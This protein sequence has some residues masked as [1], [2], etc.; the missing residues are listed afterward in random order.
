MLPE[1]STGGTDGHHQTL[2]SSSQFSFI[3]S[4]KY[5]TSTEAVLASSQ[6][7]KLFLEDINPGSSVTGI[8]VFDVPKGQTPDDLELHDS[9]LSGGV[10]VNVA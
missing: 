3:G 9:A 8:V 4:S 5:S 10:T 6:A 7:E 1:T 2:D